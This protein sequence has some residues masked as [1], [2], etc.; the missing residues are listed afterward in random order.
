MTY[1]YSYVQLI[2][3]SPAPANG[4]NVRIGTN[5]AGKYIFS[6]W[7]YAGVV[8]VIDAGMDHTSLPIK[9]TLRLSRVG[10]TCTLYIYNGADLEETLSVSHPDFTHTDL[11]S[12]QFG[13][14]LQS[15]GHMKIYLRDVQWTDQT[16]AGSTG[17]LLSDVVTDIC[18]RAGLT[19]AEIDVTALTDEVV[20]YTI[21]RQMPARPP[22]ET[23]MAGFGFDAAEEDWKIVFKKRGGSSSF[24]L[25]A[26]DLRAHA[27]GSAAPDLA[28]ETRS[29]DIELPTH[30][31]LSYE[32]LARDYEV[33]S[34][35]SVRVDKSAQVRK[36]ASLGL[37]MADAAAKQRVEILHKQMWTG[38][39]GYAFSTNYDHIGIAPADVITVMG[40]Q[41]RVT[42][43]VERG[44][45][46]DFVC[47]SEEAGAYTSAAAA[48]DLTIVVPDLTEDAY[49]P[50]FIALNLPPLD[51]DHGSAG[52]YFALYGPAASF[53]GGTI[54]RS[55]DGGASYTDVG[56]VNATRAVV[57]DCTTT[58]GNGIEG[59]LDY[60]AGVTVDLDDSDGALTSATDDELLDGANL[61]AV[62]SPGGDWEIIQFRSATLVSGRTYALTGLLRG[63]YGTAR[64]MATHASGEMFVKL[65]TLTGMDFVG[66]LTE[67]IGVS[68]LYR[69][70]NGSG[71]TGTAV[72]YVTGGLAL[73]PYQAQAPCAGR[74]ASGDVILAWARGDRYEFLDEDFPD[75]ADIDMN[76][77]T[78]AYEVDVIHSGTGA[79]LRTLTGS[80]PTVTYTAAQQSADSYPSYAVTF[81]IYQMSTVVGRGTAKRVTV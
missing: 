45:V 74:N 55:T 30:L 17:I 75:G 40:K 20:G 7:M 69:I 16:V 10:T 50:E 41:M 1:N 63:L 61:A 51:E 14:M 47:D 38:R 2:K 57:G 71:K 66:A 42:Q 36:S 22:L 78:E 37:V 12:F 32:S 79:V 48:D 23:L 52:L 46:L 76:E 6:L 9:R 64:F 77:V 72:S 56:Y 67:A 27:A 29:Q 39:H 81:D 65:T 68:Y 11:S 4:I 3:N 5:G 35:H 28:V 43:I 18:E 33:A 15:T 62:G 21:P 60:T 70:K 34:Q 49:V 25:T 8:N 44:G 13:L 53:K 73:E 24:T 80:T 54:Q 58:L 26:D 19:A 31:T 59:C